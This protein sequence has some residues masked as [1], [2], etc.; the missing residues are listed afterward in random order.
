MAL[1]QIQKKEIVIL[2]RQM[3]SFIIITGLPGYI[4]HIHLPQAQQPRQRQH[5]VQQVPLVQ[6]QVQVHQHLQ[7]RQRQYNGYSFFSIRG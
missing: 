4:I 2:I 1:L 6:V 7:V 3:D 5:Q